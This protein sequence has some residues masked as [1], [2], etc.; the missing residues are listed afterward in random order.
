MTFGLLFTFVN[1]IS[2]EISVVLS[3]SA[4]T[5][6]LCAG[7]LKMHPSGDTSATLKTEEIIHDACEVQVDI[8]SSFKVRL[9]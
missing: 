7:W 9:L 8:F 4:R 3:E 5:L 2:F 1:E 6:S